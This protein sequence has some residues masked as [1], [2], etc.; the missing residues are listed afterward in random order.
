MA[1]RQYVSV[2]ARELGRHAV[3]QP[4]LQLHVGDYGRMEGGVFG[5]GGSVFVKLGN[6]ADFSIADIRTTPSEEMGWSFTSSGMKT[7]F[8]KG[9]VD[10]GV[11]EATL[12]IECESKESLFI[13]SAKSVV[14]QIDNLQSIADALQTVDKWK[15]HWKLIREVQESRT[16]WC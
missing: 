16:V 4:G 1:E 14:E 3:W 9:N 8:V 13:R 12:Q 15:S 10:G 6:I 5:I 11:G 2:I 7:A